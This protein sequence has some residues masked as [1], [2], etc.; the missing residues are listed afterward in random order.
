MEDNIAKFL[1]LS[2]KA[3]R[4]VVTDMLVGPVVPQKMK[5]RKFALRMD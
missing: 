4:R 5:L 1:V 3:G 2:L